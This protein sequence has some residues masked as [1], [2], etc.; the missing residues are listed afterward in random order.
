VVLA[1][2][3]APAVVG[4]VVGDRDPIDPPRGCAVAAAVAGLDASADVG[5]V[6][7]IGVAVVVAVGVVAR[8]WDGVGLGADAAAG[9]IERNDRSGGWRLPPSCQTHASVDPG[10]GSKVAAPSVE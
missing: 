5:L 2:V 10:A 1:D 7:P 9:Q 3:V 6:A 8:R 4:T